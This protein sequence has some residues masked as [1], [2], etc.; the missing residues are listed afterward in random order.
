MSLSVILVTNNAGSVVK[1]ALESVAGLWDEMLVGDSGST[2][3][4]LELL[5]QYGARII[6]QK[7]ENLGERKQELI[8][9]AKGEWILVLD[10]DERVSRKLYEE[11][12][13][14]KG[15]DKLP[16]PRKFVNAD[17]VKRDSIVGYKIQYQ[18][19]VFGNPVYFGGERYRKIRLFL[20]RKGKVET[21]PIHEEI[22]VRGKTGD[23]HGVLHHHSYRSIPQLF[24]KFTRYA[25]IL[26][27]EK[28][29]KGER[30][31]LQK[32]FLY[33]PHMFWARY[34]KEKGYKDG[35]HGLVLAF[36]FAYM[37]TLTYWILLVTKTRNHVRNV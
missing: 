20:N 22:V 21:V 35:I 37:E 33:G 6:H 9:N 7:E 36:A 26:A 13:R 5:K 12:S 28:Q 24:G 3:G 30:L 19:Y 32:L 15:I 29:K 2:D 34:I 8:K 25:N 1:K 17:L 23:L 10:S 31:T 27:T 11:I 14:I 16:R 4:T 18:N